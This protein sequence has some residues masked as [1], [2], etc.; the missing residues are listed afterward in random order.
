MGSAALDPAT[1]WDPRHWI[2]RR[3]GI[4]GTGSCDGMGSAA[5][6]LVPRDLLVERKED[7]LRLEVAVE[8]AALVEMG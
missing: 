1:A 3:H 6:V 5:L 2:P 4:R 7:V 8:D